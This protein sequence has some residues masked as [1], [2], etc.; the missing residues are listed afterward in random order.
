MFLCKTITSYVVKI[1]KDEI[2][3]TDERKTNKHSRC[4]SKLMQTGRGPILSMAGSGQAGK[5]AVVG[6]AL[7]ELLDK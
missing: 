2:E 6:W 1:L 3:I 4:M 5:V 7:D